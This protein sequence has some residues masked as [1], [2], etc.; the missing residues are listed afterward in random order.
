MR[1][2]PVGQTLKNRIISLL[3]DPKI[4]SG[5]KTNTKAERGWLRVG[6]AIASWLLLSQFTSIEKE[7]SRSRNC[8]IVALGGGGR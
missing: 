1:G 6:N 8:S 2:S 4:C 7:L 3:F 5:K